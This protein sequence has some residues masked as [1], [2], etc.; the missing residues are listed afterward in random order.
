MNTRK[1]KKPAPKKKA[2]KPPAPRDPHA[3]GA[4]RLAQTVLDDVLEKKKAL[5]AALEERLTKAAGADMS[6]RDRAF[7]RAIA[8]TTIRRLGQIDAIIRKF[9]KRG[10]LPQRSRAAL[11]ILRAAAAELVFLDVPAHAAIDSANRLTS[12]HTVAR[13]F[14]PLINAVLRQVAEHKSSALDGQDAF[15]L[16]I[17]PWL[18]DRWERTYGGATA[19]AIGEACLQP[20]PL[21]LTLKEGN[22]DWGER[23][24]AAVLPNGTLRLKQAGQVERLPGFEDG[25]WWAQD[26]AATLPALLF[27]A[28]IEGQ[29]VI[30]LCAAPGGK[31]AQLAALGARVIA[32]D[33]SGGRLKRVHQNLERLSLAA[34]IVEADATKWQPPEPAPFVLLDAPCSATGTIR[35]HPDILRS[36]SEADIKSAAEVQ[37]RMLEA[38]ARFLAPGGTLIYCT[39][40]LEPEEGEDQVS[41][42]LETQPAYKRN[43]ITPEEVFG[44]PE[45]VTSAGDLR[46]LPSHWPGQGGLDGFYAARLTRA[47]ES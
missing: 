34:A 32:V 25:A 6:G 37:K 42:F 41:H 13:H 8:T 30:D 44:Q 23:L 19:R 10:K 27:G 14:R 31:T 7:A 9:T 17:P 39:C 33:R 18:R 29:T 12:R 20:P 15:A 38:A 21:D 5:D 28:A 47:N 22:T 4:R 11:A 35:R 26:A 46:T 1:P 24:G 36:K 3:L 43:P 2:A 40:S 16:N 45:F